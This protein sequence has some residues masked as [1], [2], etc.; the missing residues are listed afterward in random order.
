MAFYSYYPEKEVS[1]DGITVH[2]S[3]GGLDYTR[4]SCYRLGDNI[5]LDWGATS[6]QNIDNIIQY[7]FLTHSHMDHIGG[8]LKY[9]NDK[10]TQTSL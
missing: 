10:F 8:F 6:Y 3:W 9:V 1:A 4:T 5:L 7:I 2:G